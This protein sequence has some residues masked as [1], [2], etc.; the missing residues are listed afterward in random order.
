MS[1]QAIVP[2]S[3]SQIHN[4]GAI[5]AFRNGLTEETA[6]M[7]RSVQEFVAAMQNKLAMTLE[8]NQELGMQLV[9][10]EGRCREISLVHHSERDRMLQALEMAKN[11]IYALRQE[12][13]ATAARA[14][15]LVAAEIAAREQAVKDATTAGDVRVLAVQM[16]VQALQKEIET[17]RREAQCNADIALAER[18]AALAAEKQKGDAALAA[19]Q[20]E[21]V[22]LRL[23]LTK[24]EK[25][26]TLA[27]IEGRDSCNMMKFCYDEMLYRLNQVDRAERMTAEGLFSGLH[28]IF[29][30]IEEREVRPSESVAD[31]AIQNSDTH[32]LLTVAAAHRSHWIF[33]IIQ[34]R[35]ARQR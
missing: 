12:M 19:A 8:Q 25:L 22:E 10:S 6:E 18:N 21:L 33:P 9:A 27:R 35:M 1:S 13:T 28:N 17:L 20:Q 2:I 30:L 4:D 3:L 7:T 23:R 31:V 11:E 26:T 14:E 24:Q 34:A 29:K 15:K 16:E 5:V 32:R